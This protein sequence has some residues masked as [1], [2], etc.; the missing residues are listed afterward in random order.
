MSRFCLDCFT[1]LLLIQRNRIDFSLLTLYPVTFHNSLVSSTYVID[2]L[3]FSRSCCLCK[4][5]NFTSSFLIGVLFIFLASLLCLRPSVQCLMK[6][7]RACT[8]CLILDLWRK[9]VFHKVWCQ[10]Q[11][12]KDP[13]RQDV[14]EPFYHR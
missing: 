12:F 4:I 10:L 14:A 5:K 3:E 1:C 8:P 9:T 2:A 6:V 11:A 7:L 13:L